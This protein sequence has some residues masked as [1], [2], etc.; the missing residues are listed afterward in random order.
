MLIK[1]NIKKIAVRSSI[2]VLLFAFLP[3]ISQAQERVAKNDS[4]FSKRK[5]HFGIQVGF[6]VADFKIRHSEDFIYDDEI[7]TALTKIGP[8]FNLAILG[9]YHLS[10]NFELRTVP[11]VSFAERHIMFDTRS[12]AERVDKKIE[13][14]TVET[15]IHIKFKSDPIRD[16]KVYVFMGMKYGFDMASNS[17]ARRAEDLV[18]LSRH[19]LALDYG[20]GFEIHFPLFILAPEFKVSNGLINIHSADPFLN[21]SRTLGGLRSRM[22]MFSLNFEG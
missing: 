12:D 17:K 18:K 1:Y 11:G 20:V 8:G 22:F 13:S 3:F 4:K 21:Y 6:N 19:D 10:K 14:I 15:P 5:Y 9:S 2:G 16:F 7:L